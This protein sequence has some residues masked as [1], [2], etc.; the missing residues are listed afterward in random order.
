MLYRR[1]E[2][3][4]NGKVG[5]GAASA[6][7]LRI[8]PDND[9]M[10]SMTRKAAGRNLDKYHPRFLKTVVEGMTEAKKP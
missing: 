6:A 2:H 8:D 9:L 1:W 3:V 7:T 10:I 5:H 4:H